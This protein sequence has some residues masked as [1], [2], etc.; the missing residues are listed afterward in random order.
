MKRLFLMIVALAG[1]SGAWGHYPRKVQGIP[2]VPKQGTGQMSTFSDYPEDSDDLAVPE[3][4]FTFDMIEFWS[5]EGENRAALVIQWNDPIETNALVFGYRWDGIATGADMVRA[6]VADHPQLYG[7]IQYTNVS[8]PTDPDGGYTINGFGW[9]H[10]SDGDIGLKDTKENQ[11]YRSENGLFIHPRGYDPD[12]GGSSDY[13]YDDWESVDEDDFWGAG[14]YVS[15]WSYWVRGSRDDS[16]GYSSWGASGRVLEDGCWDGWNFAVDMLYGSW[17][18]FKAAP[19]PL[20]EGAVTEFKV[21]GL[22]YNLTNYKARKVALVAPFEMEGETLT[23]YSGDI[24]VPATLTVGD[25]TY[26]VTEIKA[27]AFENAQIDKVSIASSINKIGNYAFK[28]SSLSQLVLDEDAP[29]PALGKGVFSSCASFSQLLLPEGIKEI[30]EALFKGTAVTEISFPEGIESIGESAFEDCKNVQELN[31]PFRVKSIGAKSFSGCTGLKS[32]TVNTTFPCECAGDAFGEGAA[33]NATLNVPMGY[34]E[35]YTNAPG[36]S[37]FTKAEEFGIEVNE[38]DKFVAGGVAYVVTSVAQDGNTVKVTYHKTP[39]DKTDAQYI[40]TANKTGYTGTVVIPSIVSYQGKTFTVTAIDKMAFYY[41]DAMVSVS[42]PEGIKEIPEQTFYNCSSLT[43]VNIP[44]TISEIGTN[45]FNYCSKLAEITLPAGLTTLGSRCF[46]STAITSINIPEGV[47]TI[48]DYCFYSTALTSV[49]LGDQ[50]ETLGN[51]CFQQCKNLTMVKLPSKLRVLPSGVFSNCESLTSI[52]IPDSVESIGSSAFS[53]CS[54]LESIFLPDSL[55]SIGSSMLQYCT[56]LREVTLPAGITSL[57]SSLFNGCTSLEKVTISPDVTALPAS[58]F[59]NC[60]K[61]HTIAWIGDTVANTPGVIRLGDKVK[62]IGQYAFQGCTSMKEIM[63]PEGFTSLG[64][65]EIFKKSGLTQLVIPASVTSM[66]Q[67]YICGDNEMVTFYIC[68]TEPVTVNQFTFA[69][70]YSNKDVFPIIVPTGYADV[71]MNA[72]VWKNYKI[73]APEVE[74]LSLS[75]MKLADGVLTGSLGVGYDMELPAQFAAVNDTIALK[76]YTLTVSLEAEG[77][78]SVAVALTPSP[79]GFIKVPVNDFKG[80]E[81][82]TATAIATRS[83]GEEYAALVSHAAEVIVEDKVYFAFAEDEINAHFDQKITP[84]IVFGDKSYST[85]DLNF[86]S[87]D[88]DVA[89][90]NK[91]TGAITVKRKEGD[92]VIRAYVTENPDI[93]AEMIIHSA[94]AK[95]VNKFVLGDG[96]ENITLSYMDVYALCPTVEPAD[97]DIRS[98]DIEI[99]DPA[100]ATTYSVTAFNPTRKYFELVTHKPG[101]VDVTFRAQDGTGTATTYHFTI[102]D[103]DRTPAK[104]SWQDGTFW[105]NEDWFGHTNGSINYIEK[106]GTV[107][108]R[109]YESQN[110]YE[111]FG[112][113]S[114]YSMIF[115]GKLY[116]MSKQA[117]DGG[118]PRKG[119]GRLV[120][121]DAKTLRKLVGIDDILD[122]GDGRACVGVNSE[123]VYVGTTA[124]IAI[125]NPESLRITGKVDGIE[126]GSKYANQLGDMICAG[127]YVFA[128]KQAYGTYVIDTE[129][130]KVVA[131]LG[132]DDDGTVTAYPQG[133][134]MT[135]DGMVWIAATSSANGRATTLYCYDPEDM[136]LV[137]SVEMP[138]HLSI[139]CGWGAW[140]PTNFFA[141]HDDVAIWFGSGVE[142]SIVSGNSGYYRWDTKSDLSTLAPVFVFPKGLPG[143]DGKTEQAPYACV[144][145]DHRSNRLLIAATHG[146]SS[147]YRYTWLHFVDCAKGEI[148][149]TIRLKDYYWFPAIPVFPDKHAPEFE[150]VDDIELDLTEHKDG[151]SV[152]IKVSDRDNMDGAI[153]L[154]LFDL[155]Q[156]VELAAADGEEDDQYVTVQPKNVVRASLDKNRLLLVPLAPGDDEIMLKAESNGVSSYLSIPVKVKDINTGFHGIKTE[157][158]TMSVAG[159]RFH[160]RGFKGHT[161][162]VYT[163]G[164]SLVAE[165][166]VVD[167]DYSVTLPLADGVYI[168]ADTGSNRTVKCFVKDN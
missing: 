85:E 51:N 117:T 36:W 2:Y 137:R 134:T 136:S 56:A 17:K 78:E 102:M 76:G 31:I 32:V 111:S 41:A 73:S 64:G 130:D 93:H 92:A 38:S 24:S 46:Q 150:D 47:T 168:I 104:D 131:T 128:I 44:S 13:D 1:I 57:P 26:Y 86:I 165:F 167:D 4:E 21:D 162:R 35:T 161:M 155:P 10:D 89:S 7:L 149:K 61:L 152:E 90:V 156:T 114:Q 52:S 157:E 48:P 107:R 22:Y 163:A 84:E 8:S 127:K 42:L 58:I 39:D 164:G 69:R 54:A 87:S 97:A 132:R 138:A 25:E 124:G 94:L 68:A 71:Y 122:D 109:V 135:A 15:Y 120:V 147:N 19:N 80:K 65:R 139:T 74:S 33:E 55:R 112:C 103:S 45:A 88:T 98:Y 27:G 82:V 14:W 115:G 126:S 116:V 37:E 99:S 91:R 60:A 113:T 106:D 145:Y 28:N 12:K 5:G 159:R 125:F 50:I 123:K 158:G 20:P 142:G 11:V 121:A 40:R 166:E 105:L 83:E 100:V 49:T 108:Y 154:S 59:A 101:K 81:N 63:L 34:S 119:G 30:P 146:S 133:V 23:S 151:M 160:A 16:F 3:G 143:I 67:N 53:S 141:E 75:D 96:S 148:A 153:R 110:Q 62:S 72:S 79:D 129:T 95:G 9:D 66:S 118:D 140:R 43:S 144:R 6:V 18:N 77:I 70:N 29:V